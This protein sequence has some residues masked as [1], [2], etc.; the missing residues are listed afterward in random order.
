[1]AESSNKRSRAR[2][3]DSVEIDESDASS[4][5]LK[6]RRPARKVGRSR[7][8][9]S[10]PPPLKKA[11]SRARTPDASPVSKDSSEEASGSDG[12]G[13][14]ASEADVVAGDASSAPVRYCQSHLAVTNTTLQV[15]RAPSDGDDDDDDNPVGN[16]GDA[17]GFKSESVQDLLLIFSEREK[18]R[19]QS[20]S[21]G[22][23]E[24]CSGRWCRICRQVLLS[25]CWRAGC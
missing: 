12:D 13:D 8:S 17:P 14:E 6:G 7:Q 16:P 11:R 22:T 25:I 2:K 1:M 23:H 10:K 24:T 18:V 5:S 20:T 15:S 19:F 9:T 4:A 3:S 21:Q